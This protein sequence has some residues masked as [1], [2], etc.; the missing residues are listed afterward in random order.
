MTKSE[1][2]ICFD[3]LTRSSVVFSR[4]STIF[5]SLVF[6]VKIKSSSTQSTY[7]VVTW[8]TARFLPANQPYKEKFS[9]FDW[10]I[11]LLPEHRIK[12]TFYLCK[13]HNVLLNMRAGHFLGVFV[14]IRYNYEDGGI[15]L[16]Y[17]G[18]EIVEFVVAQKGLGS[19]GNQRG[20]VVPWVTT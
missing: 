8:D 4:M 20:N 10:V 6:A 18:D 1:Q 3:Q 13:W 11:M 5:S 15:K 17:A 16:P 12:Q 2:L 19:D 14:I 9:Y 7:L